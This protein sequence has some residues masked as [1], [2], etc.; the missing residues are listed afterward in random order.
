MDH[1]FPELNLTQLCGIASAWARRHPSINRVTLYRHAGGE[2]NDKGRRYLV[3][4]CMD[5]DAPLEQVQQI[6]TKCSPI[7]SAEFFQDLRE[8]FRDKFKSENWELFERQMKDSVPNPW[9]AENEQGCALFEG[10]DD[11]DFPELRI[12]FLKTIAARWVKKYSDVQFERILLYRYASD[13]GPSIP[14]KYAV[15]FEIQHYERVY[16]DLYDDD[17]DQTEFKRVEGANDPYERFI[18][19]T[20]FRSTMR[21][22]PEILYPDFSRAYKNIAPENCHLEWVFIP[23]YKGLSLPLQVRVD[24]GFVVLYPQK[25]KKRQHSK[26]ADKNDPQAWTFRYR[27]ADWEITFEGQIY[28][29]KNQKCINYIL[30]LVKQPGKRFGCV[31]LCQIVEGADVKDAPK[32]ENTKKE[33]GDLSQDGSFYEDGLRDHISIKKHSE[34][35]IQKMK[36]TLAEFYPKYLNNPEQHKDHWSQAKKFAETEY[37]IRINDGGGKLSFPKSKYQRNDD[38]PNII[39][40]GKNVSTNKNRFL[41]AVKEL[42]SSEKL[43]QHF[44][45]SLKSKGGYIKYTPPE[46]SPLWEIIK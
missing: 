8:L 43:Y 32:K 45:Q 40:A 2:P 15:V 44:E 34:K 11:P 30:P 29:I 18:W 31:E 27:G 36:D 38:N 39:R 14:V 23:Q 46:G 26:H 42:P 17:Y 4:I 33:A 22:S 7:D 5:D 28:S 21:E 9:I 6:Q 37:G 13:F 1:G 3:D 35:D 24:E 16:E 10:S 25:S 19:D 41:I 12:D 20:N